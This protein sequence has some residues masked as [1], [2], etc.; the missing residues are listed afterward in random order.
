MNLDSVLESNTDHDIIEVVD[1]R[2]L[3]YTKAI[4]PPPATD[5]LRLWD[6]STPSAFTVE[7]TLPWLPP[8]F[9]GSGTGTSRT[10]RGHLDVHLVDFSDPSTPLRRSGVRSVGT[11]SDHLD[12]MLYVAATT[13]DLEIFDL[14]VVGSGPSVPVPGWATPAAGAALLAAA[15]ALLGAGRIRRSSQRRR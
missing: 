1:G 15:S 2:V 6:A 7:K 3:I 5:L 8:I 11:G 9:G 4:A 12:G 10:L 14:G 13:G